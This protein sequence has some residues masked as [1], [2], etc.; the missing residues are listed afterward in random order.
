[1]PSAVSLSRAWT[2]GIRN[3]SVG[4]GQCLEERPILGVFLCAQAEDFLSLQSQYVAQIPRGQ[5]RKF[6]KHFMLEILSG[7]TDSF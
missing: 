7:L 2:I 6:L 5:L 3:A 1:M 4:R